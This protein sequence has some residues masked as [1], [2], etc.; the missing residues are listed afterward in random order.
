MTIGVTGALY[1]S[2]RTF[3]QHLEG[4]DDVV[5][6]LFVKISQDSRHTDVRVIGKTKC[7]ERSYP[8]WSMIYVGRDATPAARRVARLLDGSKDMSTAKGETMEIMLHHLVQDY[9]AGP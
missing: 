1:F 5:E 9:L 4:P 7:S 6:H 2:G 8:Y 3:V